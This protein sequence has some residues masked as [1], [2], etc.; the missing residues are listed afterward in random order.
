LRPA[1]RAAPPPPPRPSWMGKI[2]PAR[3]PSPR[4]A[5]RPAAA[6]STG[7]LTARDEELPR[8]AAAPAHP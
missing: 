2:G 5:R 1:G 8:G 4:G 3:D 7:E 6:H